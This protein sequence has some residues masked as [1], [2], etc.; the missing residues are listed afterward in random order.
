[1]S[2]NRLTIKQSSLINL[3]GAIAPIVVTL[4]TLPLLLPLVGEFRY[5]ALM[6]VWALVGYL[7]VLD[8]GLGRATSNLVA[9]MDKADPA[10]LAGALWTSL[11]LSLGMGLL[12]GLLVYAAGEWIFGAV[13]SLSVEL[14]TELIAGLPWLLIALPAATVMSVL[15][16][17]LEGRQSF[18]ALNLANITGSVLAQVLPLLGALAG[19]IDLASLL[20]LT[21]IGR[22]AGA[23]LLFQACLKHVSSS[24]PRFSRSMLG[25][26]LHFG[27]WVSVSSV[28]NPVLTLTDRF[29][30]GH[31]LDMAAVTAYTVPYSL[32]TRLSIIPASLSSVLFPRFSSA[33]GADAS[34]LM[35]RARLP[36]A[37]VM[38]PVIVAAII[39]VQPLMSLW[40]GEALGQR[41]G[42]VAEILLVGIWINAL[43]FIPYAYLQGVGRPDLTAKLHLMELVPYLALLWWAV[44]AWGVE[45]AAFA[46]SIRVGVDAI[47]LF[48]LAGGAWPDLR[49]IMLGGGLVLGAA[50]S[51]LLFLDLPLMRVLLGG[52]LAAL[53]AIWVVLYAPEELR[54]MSASILR[55]K[56]LDHPSQDA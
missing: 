14:Q 28:L 40:L 10:S 3:A 20:A 34:A 22:L 19:L 8:L 13:F 23:L 54:S 41:M 24:R 18:I 50:V 37:V 33:E 56:W 38:T 6:L 35:L 47:L 44:E 2:D 53:T 52:G 31:K 39:L 45:G 7:G 29:I 12:G 4:I 9:R 36:L 26:V 27:G 42:P 43:A 5:G 1:M 17:A 15:T 32:A 55:R 51:A 49:Q 25:Q 30:I 48:V 11:L 16:G 46:W 21:L